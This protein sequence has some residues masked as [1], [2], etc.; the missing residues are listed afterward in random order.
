MPGTEQGYGSE[1][2]DKKGWKKTH[3]LSSFGKIKNVLSIQSSY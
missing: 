2:L 3:C 1:L